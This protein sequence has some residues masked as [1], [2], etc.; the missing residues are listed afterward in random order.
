MDTV[1]GRVTLFDGQGNQVTK[2]LPAVPLTNAEARVLREF[3]KIL[4]RHNL[5]HNFRCATCGQNRLGHEGYLDWT[6][7]PDK[8]ILMCGCKQIVFFGQTL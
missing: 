2:D 6:I 1:Q 8:I 5:Q 7:G 4:Q 3:K